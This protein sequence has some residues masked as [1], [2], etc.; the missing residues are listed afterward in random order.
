MVVELSRLPLSP[1]SLE[2]DS[3]SSSAR[4]IFA[5]RGPSAA[6]CCEE[7]QGMSIY[8]AHKVLEKLQLRVHSAWTCLELY[9]SNL[10]HLLH[11][12]INLTLERKGL[13]RLFTVF[14]FLQSQRMHWPVPRLSVSCPCS[15]YMAARGA[16]LQRLAVFTGACRLADMH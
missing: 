4:R 10:F 8:F 11:L 14:L 13:H 6:T 3:G 7:P 5:C 9:G 1:L 16:A 2:V 15:A 12:R